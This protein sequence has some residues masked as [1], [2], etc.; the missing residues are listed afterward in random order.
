MTVAWPDPDI[1]PIDRVSPTFLSAMDQCLK[2]AAFRRDT[3]VRDWDRPSTRSALG[4]AAHGVT[5][6]VA[7]RQYD[8][9]EDLQDW[10]E[11]TWSTSI[12]LH[13]RRLSDAW[14]GR[15]IPEPRLWPGYARTK[16]RLLR[17]LRRQLERADIPGS[18]PLA[19]PTPGRSHSTQ[20][21]SPPPLP[22]VEHGLEDPDCGVF[23]TPDRV[24]LRGSELWVVDLKAGVHQGEMTSSQRRQLL[25]Y[26]H[27][28]KRCLGRLPD[29]ACIQDVSGHE[30]S[31]QVTLEETAETIERVKADV[32]DFN[33]SVR[34]AAVV[35]SPSPESCGRCP[36]R[37]VCHD[38]W[39]ASEGDWRFRGDVRGEIVDVDPDGWLLSDEA[40][41]AVPRRLVG[42]DGLDA[43]Q[44]A[45]V[46]AV[47][48]RP[49]GPRVLHATWDSRVR[50]F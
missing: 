49:V 23:G 5:E 21:A 41:P 42:P 2:R 26:A 14:D 47:G 15:E 4:L 33:N 10:L 36:F 3:K 48:C 30:S 46:V 50:V 19:S 31:F 29:H 28:V 45:A 43:R 34:D 39:D 40:E 17:Q 8:T 18:A 25:I 24:E 9:S 1:E 6:A 22:W 27:L 35:G 38:Y 32:R 44:G 11:R 20:H 12:A 16:T 7:R 37:V 13:Q